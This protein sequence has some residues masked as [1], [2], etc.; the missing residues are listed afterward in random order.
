VEAPENYS[1]LLSKAAGILKD[2]RQFLVEVVIAIPEFRDSL[3]VGG[4][5]PEWLVVVESNRA[6]ATTSAEPEQSVQIELCQLDGQWKISQVLS[7]DVIHAHISGASMFGEEYAAAQTTP[8]VDTRGAVNEG[9]VLGAADA[10]RRVTVPHAATKSGGATGHLDVAIGPQASAQ[11]LIRNPQGATLRRQHDP[12]DAERDIRI[13]GRFPIATGQT[14]RATL[15]NIPEYGGVKLSASIELAPVTRQIRPFVEC[16][17]IPVEITN[18]D[19]NQADSG[20]FVTKVVYLT[21]PGKTDLAL[22]GVESYVTTRLE[23][24]VDPLRE[25]R[26][27]GHVLAILR[28]GNRTPTEATGTEEVE[29]IDQK[30]DGRQPRVTE[31]HRQLAGRWLLKSCEEHGERF[32]IE[33]LKKGDIPEKTTESRKVIERWKRFAVAV[34]D[35]KTFSFGPDPREIAG[36]FDY[37][38]DYEAEPKRITLTTLAI[39][40][41]VGS[42]I[43]NEPQP[44][45]ITIRGL[46]NASQNQLTI[47]LAGQGDDFPK[48]FESEGKDVLVLHYSRDP[49]GARKSAAELPDQAGTSESVSRNVVR[50]TSKSVVVKDWT[51]LEVR[52]TP[53]EVPE[54]DLGTSSSEE[55]LVTRAYL[56]GSALSDSRF[57]VAQ[58]TPPETSEPDGLEQTIA[59]AARRIIDLIEKHCGS[60]PAI[61]FVPERMELVVSQTKSAHEQIEALLQRLKLL[62]AGSIPI[63]I[64]GISDEWTDEAHEDDISDLL[65]IDTLTESQTANAVEWC[66]ENSP[67]DNTRRLNLIPGKP[68]SVTW[69]RVP[70]TL[71]ARMVASGSRIQIRVD[72]PA[73]AGHACFAVQTIVPNGSSVVFRPG[74][75]DNF[76]WLFIPEKPNANQVSPAAPQGERGA[77]I[78]TWKAFAK[79]TDKQSQAEE[80]TVESP[81]FHW[82]NRLSGIAKNADGAGI[83]SAEVKLSVTE[84]SPLS[85]RTPWAVAGTNL[86]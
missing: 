76:A 28:L 56:V 41:K 80:G 11:V 47:A 6:T 86:L 20:N 8:R 23:P 54:S 70:L 53:V 61:D 58:Q 21:N 78:H 37:R 73:I 2:R 69:Y 44:E 4:K 52:L 84:V 45:A 3:I 65:N 59:D 5:S 57:K 40:R 33:Q 51:P 18:E 66:R 64:V 24:G 49:S 83:A 50:R 67:A 71:T 32:T 17:A 62:D 12:G 75:S 29:G 31:F 19:I 14:M 26:I 39:T 27:H 34:F 15:C 77:G 81:A 1:H 48:D 10:F 16:N 85:Q 46:I 82:P 36:R 22:A 35:D 60:C 63:T 79:Q 9:G 42:E 55:T 13:P 74:N 30:R 43:D 68:T 25:A 7:D 38:V 72:H